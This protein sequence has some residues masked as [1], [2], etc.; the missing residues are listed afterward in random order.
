[1]S[2]NAEGSPGSQLLVLE[3]HSVLGSNLGS[4]EHSPQ[5]FRITL[6]K[7]LPYRLSEVQCKVL[8]FEARGELKLWLHNHF[9]DTSK[10]IQVFSEFQLAHLR[11]RETKFVSEGCCKSKIKKFRWVIGLKTR[12]QTWKNTLLKSRELDQIRGHE[13]TYCTY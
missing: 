12:F 6:L 7:Y 2:C 8:S 3:G 1:M 5:T 13:L 10:V 4:S 11:N 9:C